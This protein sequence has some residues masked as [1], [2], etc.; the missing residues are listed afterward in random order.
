MRAFDKMEQ[1]LQNLIN[2]QS[3]SFE[4]STVPDMETF[5]FMRGRMRGLREALDIMRTVRNQTIG[6]DND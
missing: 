3:H 5:R 1:Q 4:E 2:E 6:E